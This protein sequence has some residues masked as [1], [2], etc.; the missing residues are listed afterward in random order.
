MDGEEKS[1]VQFN[2]E[3]ATLYHQLAAAKA[4]EAERTQVEA[5]LRQAKEAAENATRAKSEFVATLSHELRT[6]L[7]VLI[8]YTDLLLEGEF[9]GTTA[10]QSE[11]LERL[12]NS[13]HE[14][15]DLVSSVLDL[16][17][18]EAGRLPVEPTQVRV[19]DLLRTIEGET[20]GLRDQSC[21][22]FVWQVD[23]DLPPLYT[24]A[25]K[26]KVVIKNLIGNAVKFTKEGSITIDTQG[27][28]GGIEIRVTDTGSG[29]PPEALHTIFEPFRQVERSTARGTGLGLHIVKQMLALLG[30]TITVNSE[31]GRG[32]TFC[33]WMPASEPT[34]DA[35]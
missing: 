24:D 1:D 6:P 33:V 32:S 3:L 29:I 26:L 4:A 15:L 19:P 30:G 25:G 28:G 35:N 2:E 11:V 23:G 22:A 8:G 5:A 7:T 20:Q 21:L 16:S 9:G 18:L 27:S 31:V 12:K 34:T 14:L 13:A 17:R 10:T